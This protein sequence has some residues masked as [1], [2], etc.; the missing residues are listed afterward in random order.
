MNLAEILEYHESN[1]NRAAIAAG[2]FDDKASSYIRLLG[3][4]CAWHADRLKTLAWDGE[5][6]MA[7]F[8]ANG[9]IP[10]ILTGDEAIIEPLGQ[11]AG[12]YFTGL[13]SLLK[14][15]R[16]DKSDFNQCME[17]IKNL[18]GVFIPDILKAAI[19]SLEW[20]E[21]MK[22]GEEY[23]PLHEISQNNHEWLPDLYCS[24][25]GCAYVKEAIPEL[26]KERCFYCGSGVAHFRAYP[27]AVIR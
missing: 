3:S 21:C 10:E 4:I 2:R 19:N 7:E 11:I 1:F 13:S 20:K 18:T 16:M 6:E 25:C 8:D 15:K 9:E 27:Y 14:I 22:C 12:L 26:D 24:V 5:I 17:M 23:T